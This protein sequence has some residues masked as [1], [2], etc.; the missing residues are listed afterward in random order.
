MSKAGNFL[1][2][3]MDTNFSKAYI[4]PQCRNALNIVENSLQCKKCKRS[5]LTLDDI[6]IFTE[7]NKFWHFGQ[8]EKYNRLNDLAAVRGVYQATL[9]IFGKDKAEW[10]CNPARADQLLVTDIPVG[11]RILDAGCGWGSL[12]IGLADIA[13]EI[14]AIDI[15]IERLKFLKIWAKEENYNNIR[16][17]LANVLDPPFEDG[18]FDMIVMSGVLE[19]TGL[20]KSD[21]DPDNIQQRV[22]KNMA[23]L[24]H[25]G[26]QFILMTENRFS[27][28]YLMG[29][30]D[31]HTGLRFI[32]VMPRI[33]ANLWHRY[34]R[35]TSFRARTQSR[36]WLKRN[37]LESNFQ[38]VRFF[39][40]I[41]DY[42]CPSE[43]VDL[44][45]PIAR[46]TFI[47]TWSL[48]LK[49][50]WRRK[51]IFKIWNNFI[52]RSPSFI[53][54]ILRYIVPS[55]LIAAEK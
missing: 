18:Y 22:L 10:V 27:I 29:I 48:G 9:E 41:P 2:N 11:G 3:I 54:G 35:G 49:D 24:L 32:S 26:G 38:R 42:R 33:C 53:H 46:K 15:G 39:A 21:G 50:T 43:V 51:L 55:F 52:K 13:E 40:S 8:K 45:S 17:A 37:L 1:V 47:K 44:D 5:W 14:H 20:S 25:P 4:C 12:S 7:E 6:P 36:W 19:W 23:R 16:V 28:N 31:E 30:P 34:R